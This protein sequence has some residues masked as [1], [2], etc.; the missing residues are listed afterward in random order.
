MR[1]LMNENVPGSVISALRERGHDVLSAKESL[2][3]ERDETLLV[4]AQAEKRL[5]VT[6]DKDF[7]EL[8]FR[9]RLPALCGIVLFRLSGADPDEDNRR[10]LAALESD[11]EWTGHFDV[12]TPT[13]IRL[14]PLPQAG[15]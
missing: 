14:R 9:A 5:L 11:A 7:G 12:V 2:R 15:K 1:F 6:Q 8:A 3:G 13:R 4:R 10:I